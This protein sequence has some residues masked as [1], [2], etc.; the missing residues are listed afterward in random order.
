[1]ATS[2]IWLFFVAIS[3]IGAIGYNVAIKMAGEINAFL[4]AT[5]FTFFAL[6]SHGLCLLVYKYK[7]S[8]GGDLLFSKNSLYIAIFAGIS[9]V[10]IDLSFFFAMKY[11]SYVLTS[12][13]PV[14]A[15]M[16]LSVIA[17]YFIFSELLSLEKALGLLLG[18]LAIY[19]LVK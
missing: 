2:L 8:D 16:V 5:C 14:I 15:S 13:V 12:T 1:M 10:I 6:L 7:F 18:F 4:F 17:G 11:G 19:L 9:T 3:A